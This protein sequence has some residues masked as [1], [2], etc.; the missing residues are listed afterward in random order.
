MPSQIKKKTNPIVSV[1]IPCR[2]EEKFISRCLDSLLLQ[3]YPKEKLEVLV[4]DGLSEDKTREIIGEYIKK[5]PFIKIFDNPKKV[6]P[7]ALNIGIRNSKSETIIRMDA[8][9]TYE[10]D[11][12]SKCLKYL[13]DYNA[14]NIGGIVKVIPS[15]NTLIAKAIALTYSHPFAVGFSSFRIS[16]NQIKEVDTLFGGCYRKEIFK[17]IGL[18]NE[19]LIRSQDLEFNIRLKQ[20]GGKIILIPEIISYY[21]PKTTLKGFFKHNFTDGVWAIYPLKFIKIPFKLRHYIP[22]L[23]ISGL[24][25]LSFLSF[26]SLFFLKI[27]LAISILY[28]T[29][30]FFFSFKTVLRERNLGYFFVMP[31]AFAAR[32]FGY[33]LG[34]VFGLIKLLQKRNYGLT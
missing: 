27:F 4:I 17:K 29:L 3:D 5:Y 18:F 14:D 30:S 6:T 20:W 26:F 12:I 11:Y 1:I 32:H 19:N 8:H 28:L 24:I 2:N 10:K 13:K 15:E 34:S 9:A 33:G 23:F 31:L 16:T 22:F 7:V 21:Y 25:V